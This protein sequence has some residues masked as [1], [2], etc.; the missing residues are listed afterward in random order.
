MGERL[1]PT[2]LTVLILLAV[3]ALIGMGWRNRLKR[4]AG[5][6]ALPE[7]PDILG[8]P[9]LSVAG[10]YVATTSA[11]DWLDR[12]AV[13]SLGL[14]TNATVDVFDDGVLITR[15]GAPDVYIGAGALTEIRLESG[16][17]GKFVEKDGL[18]VLS[19]TLGETPVDTGFR[20]RAAAEKTPLRLALEKLL[21]HDGASTPSPQA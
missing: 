20:T 10:T 2:V 1:L 11:G 17:A 14:R 12:I 4:Q 15:S 13:Q 19:W 8:T 6:A 16:M 9:L 5:V 7:V 3:F 18:V 21:P